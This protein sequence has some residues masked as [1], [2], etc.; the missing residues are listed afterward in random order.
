MSPGPQKQFDR[1]EVLE[2][3]MRLFWTQGYEATGMSQLLEHVGIGRQSLYDT[4][5]DKPSL[6]RETLAHYFRTRMSPIIA[7]LRAPGRG[8]DN[9]RLVFKMWEQ[10]G[11]DTEFCGCLVGNTTAEMGSRD[12]EVARLLSSYFETLED[13]FTDA[14]E[15]AQ[16]E[17]DLREDASPRDAARTLIHTVQGVA[18][19][20]KVFRD[21]E[22][23]VGALH[24]SLVALGAR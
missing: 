15:R 23:A 22:R 20:A 24:S 6:F 19:L 1:D 4:F 14:L 17:G 12:P 18:L 16:G 11:S 3:A 5:G 10:M 13:A 8:M 9:I 2:K 7:R 21:R